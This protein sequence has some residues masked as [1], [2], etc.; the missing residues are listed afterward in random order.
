MWAASPKTPAEPREAVGNT[1]AGKF[2]LFPSGIIFFW[3]FWSHQCRAGEHRDDSG[4]G[5]A[6]HSQ[7]PAWMAT[8]G[9]W[10]KL[11]LQGVRNGRG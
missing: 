7:G 3:Q 1:K 5:R 10:E 4:V 8:T 6:L 9:M 11:R 2:P